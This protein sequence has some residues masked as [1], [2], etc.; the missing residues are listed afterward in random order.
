VEFLAGEDLVRGKAAAFIPAA[1][2]VR[3]VEQFGGLASSRIGFT[4]LCASMSSSRATTTASPPSATAT[5]EQQIT[6]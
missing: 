4:G 5:A 1:E 3:A 6:R 2:G